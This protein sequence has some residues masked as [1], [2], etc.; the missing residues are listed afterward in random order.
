M[1][2]SQ[3][4]TV[5]VTVTDGFRQLYQRIVAGAVEIKVSSIAT[6]RPAF[7]QNPNTSVP[8]TIS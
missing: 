8:P 1:P 6:L 3:Y 5:L 7:G 2:L 4:R